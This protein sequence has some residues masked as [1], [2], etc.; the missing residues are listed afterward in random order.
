MLTG[1]WAIEASYFRWDVDA[2]AEAELPLGAIWRDSPEDN[3]PDVHAINMSVAFS[4]PGDAILFTEAIS[5]S[6]FIECDGANARQRKLDQR[7]QGLR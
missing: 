3:G 4:Y 5:F 7:K 1:F 2:A 6:P